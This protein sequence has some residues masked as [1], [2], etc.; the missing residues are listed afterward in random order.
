MAI[1]S[2]CEVDNVT[3]TT[4]DENSDS[5]SNSNNYSQND[6]DSDS[7]GDSSSMDAYDEDLDTDDD[8]DAGPE[9]TRT[10]LYWHFTI[11]II[12]NETPE[13]ANLIFMKATL[14]HI[15]GEDNNSRMWVILHSGFPLRLL[16][17]ITV[18]LIVILN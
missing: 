13:K 17:Q 7:D 10:F 4:S 3:S 12:A 1:D 16:T 2:D 15:K 8:C 14:L 6:K 18:P 5:D 9:K 11:F